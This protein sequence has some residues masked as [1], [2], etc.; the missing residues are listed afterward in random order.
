L[1]W[2]VAF[3]QQS[4]RDGIKSLGESLAKFY[5]YSTLA[6]G[7]FLD[8]YLAAGSKDGLYR[9]DFWGTNIGYS[10][11]NYWLN[12][13]KAGEHNLTLGWDQTPHIYSMGALT[14]YNGLG[15]NALTLPPGLANALFN[16][17]G[18][19]VNALPGIQPPNG[20]TTPLAPGNAPAVQALINANVHRTDI[21]I[22]RD[23]FSADYR[24]T[25][26]DAW[27]IKVN[28]EHMRRT[29][30]Q[31]EGVVFSANTN[32]VVAEVPKPVSDTTQNFGL[33]GEYAGTSIWGQKFNLKLAYSGSTYQE[34]F[35]SYTVENPFCATG[36]LPGEC[37][38]NGAPSSPL[39]FMSMWPSNQANGF[40]GTL[41]AELP[42]KSRYMGTISYTMMRQN[43][44]FLPFTNAATVYTGAGYTVPGAPP[45]LPFASLN[46]AINTLLINN[47]L[48]TQITPEL[49]SKLSYRYYDIE[50][51]T[52]ELLF[53]DW[54]MNDVTNANV[55]NAAFAPVRSLSAS[56]TKQNAGAELNWRPSREW[57]LGAA[58][59][60]ER[61]DRTRADVD[62][63]NE[64]AGKFFADWKP[65]SGVTA[66]ASWLY[67]LRRYGN[68]DYLN[69]VGI[70]QWPD[71]GT[72]TRYSTA[73]RQF[74]LSNRDRNK[75]QLSLA[76][77]VMPR[78][79]ITPTLGWRYDD[80]NLNPLT[81][82]G[83][84]RDYSWN[85]GVE[86]AYIAAPGTNFLFSY[87]YE[88]HRQ[89]I[90]SAGNVAPVPPA[91]FPPA[92]YY[93]AD[94]RD[95]VNTFIVAV[96]HELIPNKLDV[97]LGYTISYAVN[98][99]PPILAPVPVPTGGQFPDITTMFQ[100]LEVLARYKFDEDQVRRLGWKGNV[101][102]KLRYVWE[103]NNVTNWQI[104]SM[105]TFM[106][107]LDNA[108][109]YMTWMAYNNPNY[110][111][112][113]IMASLAFAW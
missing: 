61:Y 103:R 72:A 100:R 112:H 55:R 90:T 17:A 14:L 26:T 2:A 73:Y 11:Q 42:W 50:N 111:V 9:A 13:S 91:T 107:S 31:I 75:G 40:T 24:Y 70:A 20:C 57:N 62:V 113:L 66:R 18:C 23:T 12:F 21:G 63:T 76:V 96:N 78:L 44:A 16:A 98:S 97:R 83:L 88:D 43:Q 59:G 52:P 19:T 45:G 30:T 3:R 15:T 34:D 54:V 46:G 67:S 94:V 68:Y 89:L 81:E 95:R 65:M 47:V 56:Y 37:A 109:G 28:Y 25:P 53:P 80:Y 77:D 5:E 38:R 41:G 8:F 35:G 10:D 60:F 32:G 82:I 29:G 84:N 79:T 110:N 7:P 33:S 74:Y 27:D 104:D 105:N 48:T 101:S 108:T 86:L 49:K 85:A 58:Y 64:H 69:F 71:G 22:R 87:I 106:Y 92:A 39:A 102:A 1:K 99:Q 51:N 4:W 6:P 93:S 36:A